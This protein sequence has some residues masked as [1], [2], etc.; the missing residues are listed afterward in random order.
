MS[1]QIT[2][3]L[4]DNVKVVKGLATGIDDDLN[5]TTPAGDWVD[6]SQYSGC[7]FIFEAGA[8]G[9]TVTFDVQQATDNAGTGTKQA[10]DAVQVVTNGTDEDTVVGVY[11]FKADLLDVDGGFDYISILADGAVSGA[12]TFIS[13]TYVLYGARYGGAAG[14]L[15]DPTD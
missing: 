5:S 8:L 3:R 6:M 9:D 7:L 10:V 14:A 11:D 13:V 12:S 4:Q 1:G 15:D 2:G